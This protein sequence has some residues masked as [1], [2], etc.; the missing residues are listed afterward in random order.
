MA[1]DTEG[2]QLYF[3]AAGTDPDLIAAY[4][5]WAAD[6]KG[7]LQGSSSFGGCEEAPGTDALGSGGPGNPNGE[8]IISNVNQDLYD[9]ALKQAVAGGRPMFASTGDTGSP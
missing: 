5:A 6:P 4:K 2:L 8:I 1:P 9:A 3:G 7:P